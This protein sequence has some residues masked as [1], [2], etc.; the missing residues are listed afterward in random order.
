MA[1][2][3]TSATDSGLSTAT[4]DSN[5]VAS[6]P[7]PVTVATPEATVPPQYADFAKKEAALRRVLTQNRAEKAAWEAE[8]ANHFSKDAILKDPVSVF[9]AAGLTAEQAA[10]AALALNPSEQVDP[11]QARIEALEAKIEALTKGKETET[12]A[13]YQAAIHQI[14]S[15]ATKLVRGN[16]AY[17][18]IQESGEVKSVV[19]LIEENFKATGEI[20]SVDE[21]ATLVEEQLLE[22]ALKVARLSK[23]QARLNTPAAQPA[24]A[25]LAASHAS[26]RAGMPAK[27]VSRSALGQ[28]TL[29]NRLNNSKPVTARDRAIAAMRGEKL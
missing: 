20:L 26:K 23:V 25:N 15:D 14:T 29:T 17:S 5:P 19:E 10:A 16:P 4:T 12:Q 7:A 28:N 27:I 1:L 2:N 24:T 21:A 18:T 6:A 22:D 13:S 11:A 9:R 3:I 8:K